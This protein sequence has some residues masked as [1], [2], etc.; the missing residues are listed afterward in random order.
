MGFKS[1]EKRRG[2]SNGGA[3]SGATRT[4]LGII[5]W[6]DPAG[7]SRWCAGRIDEAS[8]IINVNKR[9]RGGEGM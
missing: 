7:V 4:D 2:E 3:V 1:R 5:P 9:G 8:G 6:T